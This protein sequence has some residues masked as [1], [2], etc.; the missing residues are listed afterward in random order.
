M[1]DENPRTSHTSTT[2]KYSTFTEVKDL[3]YYF[4]IHWKW[5]LLGVIL[6]VF[7]AYLYLRYTI[8]EYRSHATIMIKDN[9]RNGVTDPS[10]AVFSDLGTLSNLNVNLDNEMEVIRSR[11]IIRNTIN[12]LGLN[13]TYIIQGKLKNKEIYET[14]P[15]D[16]SIHHFSKEYQNGK[17]AF[18][19]NIKG[20]DHL[21]Y[22]LYSSSGESIG[23]FTFG[24]IV[25]VP[26]GE[27]VFTKT[28]NY[29]DY[30]TSPYEISVSHFPVENTVDNYLNRLKVIKPNKNTNTIEL[31]FVGTLK[32]KSEDFLNTLIYV[33][34]QDVVFD[35]NMVFENT[36]K[37]IQ[38]RINIIAEELDDVEKQTETFKRNNHITNLEN[39]AYLYATGAN[40]FQVKE[41]EIE[42][43]IKIIES[44]QDYVI[45]NK[46][47]N[48]LPENII[49]LNTNTSSLIVEY[50]Q[51]ALERKRFLVDAGPKNIK[52]KQVEEKLDELHNTIA[53]SL[54][55]LRSNYQHQRKGLT[56]QNNIYSSKIDQVPTLERNTKKLGR[57]QNIKEQLYL[58]LLQKREETAISL[59]ITSPNAKVIDIA[60]SDKVPTTPNKGVFYIGALFIGFALPLG[61]L[62]VVKM[63]DNKVKTRRDVENLLPIPI[64]GEIPSNEGNS[65]EIVENSSIIAEAIRIMRSNLS[66][67]LPIK[68]DGLGQVLFVTSSLPKEGKTFVSTNIA[69]NMALT[70]QK[71][72]LVGLDIR[73]PKI[74]RYIATKNFGVTNYLTSKEANI[75][76]F[77]QKVQEYDN[78][79]VLPSGPIP[80]NPAELLLN[81]KVKQMFDELRQKFD[82][83]IVDS[84]PMHLVADTQLV[85][86][87]AD[88]FI[89]I[90]RANYLDKDMLHLPYSLYQENKLKNM[91]VVVNDVNAKDSYYRYKYYS[92]EY[93]DDSNAAI[94]ES[95]VDKVRKILKRKV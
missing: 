41:L 80:P 73:N 7:S 24:E 69:A 86:D 64:V 48:I 84:S 23:K 61:V 68:Q 79:Y 27:I 74:H 70:G 11:S 47:Y 19:F 12:K 22:Q 62:Y 94:T 28:K 42:T 63:M 18:S 75:D 89:Y 39:E 5:V 33:Y 38:E 65:L 71:I 10:M 44:M 87:Y 15:F 45:N 54:V 35:K 14:R 49:S 59:A 57:Q 32:S 34:N 82:M 91:C 72:V 4:L 21:K 20:I 92:Y 55:Q 56:V 77:V 88:A 37:F 17:V 50:N 46:D 60:S 83:I 90:V 53:Q 58:Y 78:F 8:P 25:K 67:V 16:L 30:I 2:F 76:E 29:I 3:L 95:I 26:Q 52:V 43:Q 93:K 81:N 66:F 31:S 13:V 40:N 1:Q 36:S 51:L 6:A 85:A 9:Q